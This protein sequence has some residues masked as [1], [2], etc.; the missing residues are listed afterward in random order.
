MKKSIEFK[1]KLINSIE[2][3]DKTQTVRVIKEHKLDNSKTIERSLELHKYHNA[4]TYESYP[5]LQELL[6]RSKFM[7]GD[8]LNVNGSSVKLS[9]TKISIN[10]MRDLDYYQLKKEGLASFPSPKNKNSFTYYDYIEN[11]YS[12]IS[13]YESYTTLMHLCYGF[14]TIVKNPFVF[15]YEFNV[16]E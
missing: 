13:L 10:K 15:V 4:K 7:V 8:T 11:Q 9:I 5:V 2:C 12:C 14:S 3:R 1:E 6:N 16:V